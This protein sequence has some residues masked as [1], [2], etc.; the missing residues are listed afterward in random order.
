MLGAS[1]VTGATTPK[2]HLVLGLAFCVSDASAR[3]HPAI[4]FKTGNAFLR[5]LPLVRSRT[6]ERA[7]AAI[8]DGGCDVHVCLR[9]LG[10][11]AI[12]TY[13][14]GDRPRSRRKGLYGR[15]QHGRSGAV[16]Q[17][18]PSGRS[19]IS[20]PGELASEGLAHD[21]QTYAKSFAANP[22]LHVET[23]ARMTLGDKVVVHDRVTGLAGGKTAEEITAY[24]VENGL[25]TNIVYLERVAR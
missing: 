15:G 19:Q 8:F 9:K 5:D 4:S 14:R 10:A 18:L 13:A 25:I 24:Q 6:K 11:R 16:P 22:H 20:L 17:P 2:Q 23:L 1:T 7:N 21:R 12:A 3:A